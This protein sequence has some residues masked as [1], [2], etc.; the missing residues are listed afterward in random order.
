MIFDY[1]FTAIDWVSERLKSVQYTSSR[2]LLWLFIAANI[3]FLIWAS[4]SPLDIVSQALGEVIPSS[5][6][7]TVQ[8]LEGGIIRE[9]LVREGERI[10]QGQTL[11]T[12]ESTGNL[13]DVNE[14]TIRLQAA[15][16]KSI[17]LKAEIN[18]Q[19][20]LHYGAEFGDKAQEVISQSIE[21]FNTRRSRLQNEMDVQQQLIEQYHY[22]LQEIS[23]RLVANK[24]TRGLLNEKISISDGLL[25][26]NIN[27]RMNH[28][29][30][31]KESSDLDGQINEAL[32]T[33]KRIAAAI[34]EA[35][36]RLKLVSNSFIE[37]AREE[38][39]DMD[40]TIEM[41]S[42]KLQ[43]DEDNL[44]RMVL[45]AP[46]D[47]T[48]K[49]LFVTTLGGIVPPGG[50]LLDIV[51]SDDRLIIEAKL[52]TEDIGYVHTGQ[53]AKIRLTSSD[54]SRFG[55]IDGEVVNISPDT[56][57]TKEGA[58]YYKIKISVAQSYFKHN[59]ERYDLY[60]GMLVQCN[61]ITGQRTVMDYLVEPF[62]S[63]LNTPL[64]ER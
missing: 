41:L 40:N 53:P 55:H 31:L 52:S 25:K 14:I 5:Q 19:K 23:A 60:S 2:L 18:E 35:E 43:K 7:K 26:L 42:S 17:R 49:S 64:S 32:A 21:L 13:A 9:I 8:H 27:N 63:K 1:V 58:S 28:L 4:Y 12:L 56:I 36:N 24:K 39:R 6:V 34:S 46:V 54:A 62:L 45:K 48:V 51:P 38:L 22:Q 44:R 61:I 11:V 29:A 15:K 33:E 20:H 50:A 10:K 30:L 3:S 57:T 59:N 47:G 37:K 16:I